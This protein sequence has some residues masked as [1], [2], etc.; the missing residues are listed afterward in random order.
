MALHFLNGKSKIEILPEDVQNLSVGN[1]ISAKYTYVFIP[2]T[3][4]FL[5]YFELI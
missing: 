2:F 3:L 5:M 1:L 4:Y